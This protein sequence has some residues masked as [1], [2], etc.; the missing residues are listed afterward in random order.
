MKKIFILTGEPSGDKLASKVIANLKASKPDIEYLSVGG[1]CLKALGVKSLYDLNEVTYLGF[2]KVL[3]NI[4]KIKKKINETVNKIIEFNPDILFSVDSPDF[5]LRVAERVKKLKINIKTIHY[6]APQVWIWREHRVKKL[7]NFLDHILLL[8]PFEKQYFEKENINCTFV[9]HPLLEDNEKNKIDIKNVI[10]ENKK[11]ISIFSGSRTSEIS[12]LTPILLKFIK[13]VKEKHNDIYFIFHT[14]NEHRKT[15]KNLVCKENIKNCDVI[16]DEKIKSYIL[17]KSTF[18]V[19]KSGT[20]SLEICNANVPSIIIYKINF[21]NFIIVKMLLKVKFA[22]I[23]NIAA[24]KEIIPELLQKK[25]NAKNIFNKV[26][27]FLT[28]PDLSTNQINQFKEIIKDFRTDKSSDLASS[29][30]I[31]SF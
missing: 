23:I 19:A 3:L 6:V 10:S 1:E 11:I 18:A 13:M 4:F 28:N 25:C 12:V 30:L 22:N 27:E 16:S 8:F 20:I 5:T 17:K 21:I 24:G 9:G 31:N 14:T 15:V 29:V 2:T 26:D 7:K